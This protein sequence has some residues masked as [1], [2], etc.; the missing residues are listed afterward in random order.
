MFD[1]KVIDLPLEER[2]KFYYRTGK[3]K[4]LLNEMI[5]RIDYLKWKGIDVK[6]N[7]LVPEN[8][9]LENEEEMKDAIFS[10]HG[11]LDDK[12]RQWNLYLGMR[13]ALEDKKICPENLRHLYQIISKNIMELEDKSMGEFYRTSK[14]Y[15]CH[16]NGLFPDYTEAPQPANIDRLMDSYFSYIYKEEETS[17]MDIFLKSQIMHLY[18]VY[19]HPYIDGNGRSARLVSTWYLL[20]HKAEEFVLFNKA[21]SNN[22]EEYRRVVRKS[23]ATKDFTHYLVFILTKL[24]QELDKIIEINQLEESLTTSFSHSERQ[25][26]EFI[27]SLENPTIKDVLSKYRYYDSDNKQKILEEKILPML[28]KGILVEEKG[29]IFLGTKHKERLNQ[30]GG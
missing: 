11:T 10:S 20:K 4:T 19:V 7:L 3:I 16:S 9:E 27:I 25:L 18:F 22:K 13:Y 17:K 8:L 12:I 24:K 21:I 14:E 15:I 23:I 30:Y 2:T 29:H 6:K 5:H 1:K 26:L 28:E